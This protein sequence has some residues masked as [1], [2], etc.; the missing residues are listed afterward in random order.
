MLKIIVITA[1]ALGL[2]GAPGAA[3]QPLPTLGT[4]APSIK[5]TPLQKFVVP[6]TNHETVIG[7]AEIAPNVSTGRHTHSGPES[8]YLLDGE[9]TLIVEG[10]PDKPLKTGESYQVPPGAVHDAKAGP[11]GAKVIA[12]YVV[13]KGKPL[14]TPAQ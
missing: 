13:E 14:A 10:Q 4:S 11:Q 3:A 12:T 5:R 2:P 7:I 6:G 9:F 8:G 1:A